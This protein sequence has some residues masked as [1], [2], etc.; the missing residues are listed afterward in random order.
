MGYFE[1]HKTQK[2]Y[3]QRYYFASKL[4]IMR[5]LRQV[6]CITQ[7]EVRKTAFALFR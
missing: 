4:V 2:D 7:R 3:S 1:I 6:K 5:L